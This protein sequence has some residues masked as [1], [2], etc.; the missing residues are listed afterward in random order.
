MALSNDDLDFLTVVS[1][2]GEV[3]VV[4]GRKAKP[5]ERLMA[6]RMRR[7]V[8]SGLA[9]FSG[10][11]DVQITRFALTPAGERAVGGFEATVQEP[12]TLTQENLA[13]AQEQ[14][15]ARDLEAER[16]LR[17]KLAYYAEIEARKVE[18]RLAQ[19]RGE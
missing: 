19:N 7:F 14:R 2:M 11:A 12:P 3:A 15:R 5:T 8:E 18:A 1:I 10:R 16:P 4:E 9:T 13:L 17:E 6:A